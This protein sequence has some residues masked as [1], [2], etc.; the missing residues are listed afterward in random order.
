MNNGGRFSNRGGG[1]GRGQAGGH[2]A[3]SEPNNDWSNRGRPPAANRPQGGATVPFNLGPAMTIAPGLSASLSHG[4]SVTEEQKA[5]EEA[6]LERLL[7]QKQK[8]D[9]LE[10]IEKEKESE[11]ERERERERERIEALAK[12]R[13]RAEAERLMAA[14]ADARRSLPPAPAQSFPPQ[15]QMPPTIAP[16][17]DKWQRR[18]LSPPR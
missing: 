3:Y 9:E 6:R 1:G 17:E 4:E 5:L 7:L 2:G 14:A 16:E 8:T 10:R 11:K 13:Q 12:E 18:K 15:R